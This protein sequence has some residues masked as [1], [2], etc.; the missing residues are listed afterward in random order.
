VKQ[1]DLFPLDWRIVIP[2][3]PQ[4]YQVGHYTM[5]AGPFCCVGDWIW[6]AK[7][8]STAVATHPER[9]KVYPSHCPFQVGK[10][11][12]G[13]VIESVELAHVSTGWVWILHMREINDTDLT[14]F[15]DM[16]RGRPEPKNNQ[17]PTDEE[18]YNDL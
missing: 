5:T 18:L 10:S 9:S 15:W 17:W 2:L 7:P 13:G 6:H 1:L 14:P 3:E 4:P 8:G 16:L 11:Y 12:Q